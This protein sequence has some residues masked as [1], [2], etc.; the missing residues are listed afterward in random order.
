MKP[1]LTLA[2]CTLSVFGMGGIRR[3]GTARRGLAFGMR[4]LATIPKANE[5]HGQ[6]PRYYRRIVLGNY[7]GKAISW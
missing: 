2:D 1:L 4:V 3:G 6:R 7:W 5:V